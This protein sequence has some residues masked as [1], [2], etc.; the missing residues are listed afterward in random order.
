CAQSGSRQ[1]AG[2]DGDEPV[3]N[4][5]RIFEKPAF[6][7]TGCTRAVAVI[8][9]AMTRAHEQTGLREPAH[10]TAQMRTVD[11]KNLELIS[12]NPPHPACR[13]HRLAIGRHYVG[14]PE[15]SQAALA[16]RKIVKTPEGAPRM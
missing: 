3:L 4:F 12:F 5:V 14:I 8:S 11:C 6:R 16:C 15:R 10:R 1:L 13:V 2:L 7:R 9:S